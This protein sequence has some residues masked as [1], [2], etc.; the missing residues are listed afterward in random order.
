MENELL[1]PKK[2]KKQWFIGDDIGNLL[3]FIKHFS[4]KDINLANNNYACRNE[5][6]NLLTFNFNVFD[7][8]FKEDLKALNWFNPEFD[9]QPEIERKLP[10]FLSFIVLFGFFQMCNKIILIILELVGP[11]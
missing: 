3:Q 7:M 6:F 10:V 5:L 4:I 1:F 11:S 2:K 9:D 8:N